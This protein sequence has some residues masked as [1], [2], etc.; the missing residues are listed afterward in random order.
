MTSRN[1]G[2]KS[3]SGFTL[4]E[5][6]VVIAIIGILVALLLP[7][8]QAAREAARRMSCTN[9]LKQWSLSLHTH[10]DAKNELPGL[11]PST[12]RGYSPQIRLAPFIEQV[13][14]FQTL[15]F[16]QD[17]L[18]GTNTMSGTDW[19]MTHAITAAE[20]ALP[21]ARCPSD[22]GASKRKTTY[23]REE[24]RRIADGAAPLEGG[25]TNYMVCTGS[26][27]SRYRAPGRYSIPN[28]NP[29]GG[30]VETVPNGMFWHTY[31]PKMT[32]PADTVIDETAPSLAAVSDGLSNTMAFAEALVG[33]DDA[34]QNAWNGQY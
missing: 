23:S 17:L 25:T 4:V 22:G 26:D 6:L 10:S 11:A 33:N 5:L 15:D 28:T 30:T 21:L 32:K 31:D 24:G 7:A 9:N 27:Y 3:R 1:A 20:A 8:V 13:A 16:E 12:K 34:S 19:F 2:K 18:S 14:V 29:A